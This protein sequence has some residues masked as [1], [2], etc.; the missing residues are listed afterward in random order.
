[1]NTLPAMNGIASGMLIVGDPGDFGGSK[2]SSDDVDVVALG[3]AVFP[4]CIRFNTT[5][6]LFLGPGSSSAG[7]PLRFSGCL[8]MAV[9][10]NK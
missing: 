4:I 2:G 7:D 9:T 10:G 5:A 6:C 8:L 1:M 3:V